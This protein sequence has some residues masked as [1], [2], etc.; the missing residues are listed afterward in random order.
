M[1]KFTKRML[2]ACFG[3]VLIFLLFQSYF[4]QTQNEDILDKKINVVV[5]KG[6]LY[7]VCAQ[8]G[9]L[10][11]I[12]IGFEGG[13][14]MDMGAG[15]II[16]IESG[17][18]R[19]ILDSIIKQE[20]DYKWEVQ[21]G[22]VNIYP[23]RSRDDVIKTL[24]ETNFENFSSKKEGGR[25]EIARY[26]EDHYKIVTFLNSR[27]IQLSLFT[28]ADLYAKDETTDVYISSVDLRGVLNKVVKDSGDSKLWSI[29]RAKNGDIFLAF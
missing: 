28:R 15:K 12:P 1:T 17:T 3:A 7:Q 23:V 8:F 21:D 29:S 26:I 2:T 13:I 11:G 25:Q 18:L 14:G 20:P 10:E 4:G 19:E 27:Q 6:T 22:V 9:S 16:E 5:K 24:L